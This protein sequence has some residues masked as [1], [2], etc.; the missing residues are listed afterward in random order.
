[1]DK[2]H[3]LYNDETYFTLYLIQTSFNDQAKLTNP[4]IFLNITHTYSIP[5]L[6]VV[7]KIFIL[8]NFEWISIIIILFYY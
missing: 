3:P 2:V 6:F 5:I 7:N 1:M 4:K 8:F